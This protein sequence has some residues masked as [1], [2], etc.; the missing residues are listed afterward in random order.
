MHL[1]LKSALPTKLMSQVRAVAITENASLILADS[2][3]YASGYNRDEQLPRLVMQRIMFRTK[4]GR[5]IR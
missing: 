1:M 3:I 2:G 4:Q 5:Q